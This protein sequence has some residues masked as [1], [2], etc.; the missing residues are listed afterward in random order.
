MLKAEL[1]PLPVCALISCRGATKGPMLTLKVLC[2]CVWIAAQQELSRVQPHPP[3]SATSERP[4]ARASRDDESPQSSLL[5]GSRNGSE[6]FRWATS[7]GPSESRCPSNHCAFSLPCNWFPC[8]VGPAHY[9][10]HCGV[11]LGSS[12]WIEQQWIDERGSE[13]LVKTSSESDKLSQCF[14]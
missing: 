7:G 13:L 1:P 9:Q 4:T 3:P 10:E 6:H 8:C 2:C 14:W 12:C 11:G 5:R